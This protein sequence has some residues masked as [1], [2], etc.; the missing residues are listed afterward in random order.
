MIIYQ[1]YI[2]VN[3]MLDR[4][5]KILYFKFQILNISFYQTIKQKRKIKGS[6][7]LMKKIK[8][9][10]LKKIYKSNLTQD[11]LLFLIYIFQISNNN[12]IANVYYK[13]ITNIIDCSVSNF[14]AVVSSLK[15]KGFITIKKCDECKQEITVNVSGNTFNTKSKIK[16]YVDANSKI[17]DIEILKNLR[18]GTIRVLLYLIFRISKQKSRV[19]TNNANKLNYK[20]I[21]TICLEVG[22]SRRML[23]QYSQELEKANIL[24]IFLKKDKNNKVFKLLSINS[25]LLEKPTIEVTEKSKTVTIKE[26]SVHRY[27]TNIIKN[28]CRRK[29]INYDERN[30]NDT[31]ILMNQYWQIAI[32]KNKDILDIMRNVFNNLKDKLNSIIVHNIIKALINNN[33]NNKLIVY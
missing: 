6:D 22:I 3:T 20:N 1:K 21:E 9:E 25:D 33:F 4:L 5:N 16:N 17:F 18:A 14:Y 32:S 19:S 10:L 31:A 2:K 7:I 26:N 28:L 30:L 13:N 27:Y 23:N 11:E 29:N 24:T 8:D 12:G 15:N